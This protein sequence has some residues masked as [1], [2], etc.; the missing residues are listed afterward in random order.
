MRILLYF[1]GLVMGGYM[2]ADGIFVI[3]NGR[4]MGGEKPGPW[5]YLFQKLNIDVFRLGPMFLVF[6]LVWLIF[7]FGIWTDKTWFRTLGIIISI[8]SLWYLPVGTIV[9][10]CAIAILLNS[11]I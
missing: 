1:L 5:S 7:L 8:A 4:Y 6:G 11:D 9:S 3:V 2:L 10:L